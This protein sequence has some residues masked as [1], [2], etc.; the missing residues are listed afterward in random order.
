MRFPN[1]TVASTAW[2]H[3]LMLSGVTVRGSTSPK[4]QA[5]RD[6][7]LAEGERVQRDLINYAQA[8]QAAL[9]SVKII[10]ENIGQWQKS[11]PRCAR[12]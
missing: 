7:R 5:V 4:T 3:A 10:T 11:R 9:A 6:C 2:R 8:T 12:G 1:D